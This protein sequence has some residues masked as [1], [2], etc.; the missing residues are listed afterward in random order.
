TADRIALA[1]QARQLSLERAATRMLQRSLLPASL[2]ECHGF[3]FGS[4]YVPAED[5]GVGGDWYDVFQ[6]PEGEVWMI[7]GDV[8]GHGLRAGVV[9]SRLRSTIRAYAMERRSPAEVLTLTDRKIQHFEPDEMATV[10][11]ARLDPP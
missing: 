5:L 11:C 2:P 7:I 8:A 9:M 6:L 4:R 1:V 3:E 10:L